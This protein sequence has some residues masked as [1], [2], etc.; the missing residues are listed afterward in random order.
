VFA[1]LYTHGRIT[2]QNDKYSQRLDLKM[3]VCI[4]DY[5][6]L[7]DILWDY[8]LPTITAEDAFYFY[9]KR[10]NYVA[11]NEILPFEKAFI[12]ELTNKYGAGLLMVAA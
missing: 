2:Y 8:N 10:L 3:Q 11:A 7:K 5:P 12:E 4:Q 1:I 9:E 6:V